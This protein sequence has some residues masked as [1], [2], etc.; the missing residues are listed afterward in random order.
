MIFIEKDQE[1]KIS[2]LDIEITRKENDF[3]KI[4]WYRKKTY[5]ARFLNFTSHH[6]IEQKKAIV[7]NLVDK[8][9]KL[10]HQEFHQNNLK[11]IKTFLLANN[12]PS[13]FIDIHM[14]KRVKLLNSGK[15]KN[16][17]KCDFSK[18]RK[19]VVPFH[20]YFTPQI[21]KLTNEL[22]FIPINRVDNKF[23]S[24]IKLGKDK[25]NIKE[26]SGIVYKINYDY[27]ACY[28][29]Q[30]GRQLKVRLKKHTKDL[31]NNIKS[32][33]VIHNKDNYHVF[34]M[35]IVKVL[36]TEKHKGKRLFSETMN[37]QYFDNTVNIELKILI[38]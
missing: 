4:N 5:S 18:K 19:I 29:G 34:D 22:D 11:L 28:I 31:K 24:M 37:I 30:S 10:L 21:N 7:Y 14:E 23:D 27:E 2:F 20:K 12:Y 35:S 25:D 13:D 26:K 9:I 15:L 8:G 38:I 1:E 33:L 16:I 36:D 32:A 3:C 17:Q 6:P